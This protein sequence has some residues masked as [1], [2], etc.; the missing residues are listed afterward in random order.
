MASTDEQEIN[1]ALIAQQ[2]EVLTLSTQEKILTATETYKNLFEGTVTQFPPTLAATIN[3]FQKLYHKRDWQGFLAIQQEALLKSNAKVICCTSDDY[4]PL[5]KQT[6]RAPPLLYVRGS[7][8]NLHL[9]QIA[10]VGSR[11]MTRSGQ[12]NALTWS[13]FLADSGFTITSGLALGVDGTAH[14]G[15]LQVSAGTTIA[16]MATG[17]DKVYPKRHQKLGDRIVDAGGTLVTEFPPGINPL[18]RHFPQRNRI[19]SGLSLGVLVVEAAIKS[20]S[21]ITARTALEQNREVFAIPGSIHSP[22][23]KGCHLLIKQGAHLVETADEVVAELGGALG[24]FGEA[25]VKQQSKKSKLDLDKTQ[26]ELLD[27]LS[28]DPV[29]LDTLVELSKWPIGKL[30]P[31]LVSLELSGFIANDNGFYQRLI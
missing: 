19:I 13:R 20:G 4:P 30:A 15:A 3:V 23:S 29:S 21:L 14:E 8:T 31:V 5:L 1:Y 24:G 25:I 26:I 17:I 11:Q 16:V 9:P 27:I 22:Q 28:F 10:I 7:V 2:I 12:Q 6:S 18:A